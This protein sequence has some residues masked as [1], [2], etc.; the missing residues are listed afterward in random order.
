[1]QQA[2]C[3]TIMILT[4]IVMIFTMT[5]TMTSIMMMIF[6]AP[7]LRVWRTSLVLSGQLIH[8]SED[9]SMSRDVNWNDPRLSK[10]VESN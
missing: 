6:P 10:C 9:V 5:V 1:M 8:G 4:M 2:C 7:V 3:I